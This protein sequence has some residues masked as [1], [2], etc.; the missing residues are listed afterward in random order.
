MTQNG[1]KYYRK[2]DKF[3]DNST[4][5]VNIYGKNKKE[6]T[7]KIVIKIEEI[8]DNSKENNYFL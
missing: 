4:R 2:I 6:I 7:G 1:S 3:V 5:N 8:V